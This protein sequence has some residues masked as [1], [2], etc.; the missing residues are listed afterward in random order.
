MTN[1][2][3]SLFFS[4]IILRTMAKFQK[5]KNIFRFNRKTSLYLILFLQREL[6]CI[7]M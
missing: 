6:M 3:I 2:L 7:I 1:F 4:K 5:G